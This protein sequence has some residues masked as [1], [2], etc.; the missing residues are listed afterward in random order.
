MKTIV[1]GLQKKEEK[2]KLKSLICSIAVGTALLCATAAGA[3]TFTTTDGVLSIDSPTDAWILQNDPNH[4]FTISDGKNTITIDHLANGENLPAVQVADNS[5]PAVFDAFV[6]TKNEVFVVKAL[7]A[8]QSDL[9]SLMTAISSIKVLQ[10]DT[11]T[12]LQTTSAPQ[13]SEF[14]IRPIN[15]TYYITGEGVRIRSSY[16]TDSAELGVANTG[17]ALTVKGAVTRNGSDYGWYQVAYNGSDGYVSASFLSENKP[18][19]K[20][21]TAATPTPTPAGAPV[22]VEAGFTVYDENGTNQGLLRLYSDGKYYSN[23]MMPY[24]SNGDGS[25]SG[26]K[27]GDTLYSYVKSNPST[28]EPLASGFTC[29]DGNGNIQGLLVPYSDGYY[30]SNDSMRYTDNGDGSYYGIDTGDTLYDYNPEYQV[31]EDVYESDGSDEDEANSS[32]YLESQGSGRPVYVFPGGG[33]YYDSDGTEYYN[34]GD[35]T[36][37]DENG[38]VFDVA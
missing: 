24:V 10:F 20:A 16:S 2:M 22:Q 21:A 27:T 18:A 33:A 14:G 26:T 28:P 11:K 30:H 6:S 29:Y 7:A 3:A 19:A 17:D 23:D 1:P 25:Y 13:T 31:P 34:N 32:I 38:D 36:F 4:W 37:T 8:E 35:G 12:A 5:Y 9:Q 15:G